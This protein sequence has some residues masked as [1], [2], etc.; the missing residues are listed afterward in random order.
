VK[1]PAPPLPTRTGT[2]EARQTFVEIETD[3]EKKSRRGRTR[4]TGRPGA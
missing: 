2:P 1:P 3:G 4:K